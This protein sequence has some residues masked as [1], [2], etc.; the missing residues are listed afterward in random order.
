MTFCVCFR[1][2]SV[3]LP[4]CFRYAGKLVSLSKEPKNLWNISLECVSSLWNAF[5]M[6]PF[7]R[8]PIA[9]VDL[10]FCFRFAS[11]MRVKLYG[12]KASEKGACLLEGISAVLILCSP[13]YNPYFKLL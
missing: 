13:S 1:S 12:S 2:A 9:S 11:V 6:G 3:P 7:R 5:R 10:P 8:N 4:F